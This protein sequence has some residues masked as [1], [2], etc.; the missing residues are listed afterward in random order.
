V[1]EPVVVTGLGVV[2]PLGTTVGGF[3]ADLIAGS[4]AV[5]PVKTFDVSECAARSAAAVTSFEPTKWIA[6]LKLRRLD[7]TSQYAVAVARQALDA[8]G[9]PYGA[10][11]DD[12][13]GVVLGTYTAGGSPTEE[14]L[15]KLFTLGPLNVPTLIFNATV[16]NIAASVI[17]L[18]LKLRGPNVTVSQKEASGL[19]AIGQA[20]DLLRTGQARVLVSGGVDALYP[21]FFRVHDS[22]R[23]LSHENGAPEGSRP[24]DATR[25]GFVLGEGGFGATLE[26][27][28]TAR[29][30]GATVYAHVL[31]SER[32]GATTGL[33]QWP[34][35]SEPIARVMRRALATAGLDASAVDVVYASA[36]SSRGLDGTEAQALSDVF[37]GSRTVVTS[38][39]GAIGESSAAGAAAIVA[40]VACG[41]AGYAPPIAGLTV[42][43]AAC[44]G[45]RLATRAERVGPIALVNS[46]ASGGALTSVVLRA[47][48]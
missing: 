24:F 44:A 48:V 39:K 13:I 9:I 20:V 16:G 27:E 11:P 1:P 3:T 45:L 5:A 15:E 30:R 37:G 4:S 31:S 2:S 18:E 34:S 14:Y 46:A 25:N 35:S 8:A 26:L 33:N 38:I 43:D 28:S 10:E 7:V 6:P 19:L 47:A 22:F 41:R 32:G 21:L 12:A 40:A 36:N 29:A 23:V 17:G 42:P